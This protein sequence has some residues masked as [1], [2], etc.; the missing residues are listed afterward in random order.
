MKKLKTMLI[1]GL[2]LLMLLPAAVNAAPYKT[3]TYSPEKEFLT[4]P[5]VYVPDVYVDSKYIGLETPFDNPRDLFVAPDEKV[6]IA[7]AENN[8]ILVLTRYYKFDFEIKTFVN[9]YG[10]PDTFANPAGVFVNEKNIYVCDSDNNRIVLFDLEGNFV[11]IIPEPESSLFEEGEIYKPV[12]CAV[13]QYGRIFVISSTTYQGVMVISDEGE[14]YGF[15]GAQNDTLSPLQKLLRRFQTKEQRAKTEEVTS[16]ELNNI[17]IDKDNF[18]YITTSALEDADLEAQID[19][20]ESATSPVKKLNASGN[21][22]MKRNGEFAPSGEV[23]TLNTATAEIKGASK[24]VDVAIGPT[25]TWS[26]IDQKRSKVFTYDDGGNLLFAFGDMGTQEGNISELKAITYQGSKMLLLDSANDTITVYRRTE[27]GD[28]LINA[29]QNDIDRLYDRATDDWTEIL[30]RNIN[31]SIAY[32]QLGKASARSA[33]YDEAMAYFRR[34]LDTTEYSAAYKEVRTEWG[35]KFF[36]IIPVV[37]VAVFVAIVKFFGY[38][39]KVNR[40]A[41]LKIGRKSLKEEI[42]YAFHILFH[43][44]D[45]FWDLKHEKRGSVKSAFIILFAT[46]IAFFYRSVGTAYI[47]APK[48]AATLT[49]LGSISAVVIPLLLWVIA[50]WCFTT[51]FEGEGSLKDIFVASCYSLTPL[52]IIMIPT[53]LLSHVILEDEKGILTL[54][55]ALAFIWMGLLLVFGM[56]TTHDYSMG[57]N[58]FACIITVIG[59]AVIMF[60][61][62]LFSTLMAKIVS[63]ISNIVIELSY[64]M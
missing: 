22:V 41:A 4:S 40:R 64:R 12:A 48:D 20:K 42:L 21:D 34:I 61:A 44:F 16:K 7:D 11:K 25:G 56:M 36:W 50:N 46:V 38:A 23:K 5:D 18:I 3:Y 54:L 14:F 9:D 26:I 58:I 53:V 32:L 17:S 59:M 33:N 45:G 19:S 39:G 13:D 37:I 57:K 27:Y 62:I 31:Y 51:L 2:T 6:Y 60:I 55:Y 30:K 28:L 63:F 29:L 43:P 8:R 35:A 52:P 49:I 24:L 15:I 10:V 47:H 1:M